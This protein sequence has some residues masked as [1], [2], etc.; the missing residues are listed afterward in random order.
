[1][2][3]Y[4]RFFIGNYFLLISCLIIPKIVEVTVNTSLVIP[5]QEPTM[6][7]YVTIQADMGMARNLEMRGFCCQK[8]ITER[9]EAV[10]GKT[11]NHP[12]QVS[13]TEKQAQPRNTNKKGR[14]S[15]PFRSVTRNVL[16][17]AM[18]IAATA[19]PEKLYISP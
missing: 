10:A 3:M 9:N 13:Q 6:V 1:M 4:L 14:R 19:A 15:I 11:L 17:R 12:P 18:P 7:E 2:L 16:S 8:L 5:A